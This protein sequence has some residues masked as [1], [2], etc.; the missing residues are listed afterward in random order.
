MKHILTQVSAQNYSELIN[1]YLSIECY[2]YSTILQLYSL[3][4]RDLLY[5][6]NTIMQAC[7]SEKRKI[8]A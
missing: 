5:S 6:S 2:S 3:T 7:F 4:V 8:R 1:C